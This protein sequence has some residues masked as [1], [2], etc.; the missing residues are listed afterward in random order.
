MQ[1]VEDLSFQTLTNE[2]AIPY[3]FSSSLIPNGDDLFVTP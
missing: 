3:P 2:N 1:L